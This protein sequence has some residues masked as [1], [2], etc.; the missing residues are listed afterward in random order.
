V[1][2]AGKSPSVAGTNTSF[3][4]LEQDVLSALQNLGCTRPAAEQ[5]LLKARERGASQEFE[6]YFRAALAAMR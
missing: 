2:A 1:D 3:S 5:A 6:P 4:A